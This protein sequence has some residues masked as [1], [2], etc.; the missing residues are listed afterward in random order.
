MDPPLPQCYTLFTRDNDY[1]FGQKVSGELEFL[2]QYFTKLHWH[3][4]L[5]NLAQKLRERSSPALFNSFKDF[6]KLLQ[7]GV[8]EELLKRISGVRSSAELADQLLAIF[9]P[10][11]KLK[12]KQQQKPN[13]KQA[14][15]PQPR[16]N[17]NAVNYYC[18]LNG[19]DVSW[20]KIQKRIKV[21][22][23]PD[24][25]YKDDFR[26]PAPNAIPTVEEIHMME[27]KLHLLELPFQIPRDAF[28]SLL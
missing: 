5:W 9:S 20:T 21:T 16:L 11:Q 17:L 6:P 25:P 7:Q 18:A 27:K 12:S 14:A 26:P 28:V 3:W 8:D 2:K 13:I 4:D 22:K 15:K 24:K 10:Q 1:T 23:K 19:F